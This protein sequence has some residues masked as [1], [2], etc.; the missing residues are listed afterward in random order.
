VFCGRARTYGGIRR[1]G[2][3][4]GLRIGGFHGLFEFGLLLADTQDEESSVKHPHA[5]G[6]PLLASLSNGI[7]RGVFAAS[8]QTRQ[9]PPLRRKN[10][11]ARRLHALQDF[12]FAQRVVAGLGALEDALDDLVADWKAALLQPEKNVSI[13]RSWGRCR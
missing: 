1:Q 7:A 9:A 11:S 8:P 5:F 2:V 12:G 10:C 4:R 13:S 3:S 6:C